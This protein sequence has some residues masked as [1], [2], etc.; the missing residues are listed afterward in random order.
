MK[1]S[2][3]NGVD[4]VRKALYPSEQFGILSELQRDTLVR[5]QSPVANYGGNLSDEDRKRLHNNGRARARYLLRFLSICVGCGADAVERHHID[6]DPTNNVPENLVGLCQHCHQLAHGRKKEV[7]G[8]SWAWRNP[9]PSSLPQSSPN[10]EKE[11]VS[12]ALKK[13]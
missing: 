12:W 5:Q 3:D 7:S 13:L 6:S 11:K 1:F 4:E 10:Y 2:K 9:Y 8:T